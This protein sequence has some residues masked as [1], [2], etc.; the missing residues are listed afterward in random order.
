MSLTA[1]DKLSIRQQQLRETLTSLS[2]VKS[3]WAATL[4]EWEVD[5]VKHGGP[6]FCACG[7]N[8]IY[9]ICWLCNRE[10][11]ARIIVGSVC[12]KQFLEIDVSHLL[13]DLQELEKKWTARLHDLTIGWV[14]DKGWITSWEEDFLFSV[15]RRRQL[16]PRQQQKLQQINRQLWDRWYQYG[17]ML[18][19]SSATSLSAPPTPLIL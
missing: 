10:T 7:H 9:K 2:K 11:A 5:C 3:P 18:E 4:N 13:T 15:Q 14:A 16:T 8:P 6:H 12:V 1:L 17:K 19:A